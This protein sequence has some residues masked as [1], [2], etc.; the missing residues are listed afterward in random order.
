MRSIIFAVCLIVASA[1][2]FAQTDLTVSLPPGETS[3]TDIGMYRVAYQ[4]YDGQI[5][6]MPDSWVGHFEPVSG[7][8]YMPGGNVSGRPT[9]LLHSPWHGNPGKMWV[10]YRLKLPQIKPLRLGFGIAMGPGMMEPNKSDGVTFSAFVND[11]ELMRE[12]CTSETWKDFT[13]DLDEYAGQ[14]ISVRLQVEPGPNNSPSFDYSYFG[15]PRITAG[16]GAEARAQLVKQLVNTKA[17]LATATADMRALSND[18][19]HGVTPSNLLPGK[20]ALTAKGGG[21]DFTYTGK[22]CTVVYHYE[23]RTGTLADF[24]VSLDGGRAL[25]PAD[26]GGVFGEKRIEDRTERVMLTGGKALAVT[27]EGEKLKVRWEYPADGGPVAVDWTFGI[28]GK[29]LTVEAQCAEPVLVGLSLG[30]VSQ[31]PMRRMLAVPYLP[32]NGMPLCYLPAEN[33]YVSRYLNWMVSHASTCPQG[34]ASYSKKTDGTRNALVESGYV[35]VSPNVN[36]VLPNIPWEASPYVKLL[37]PLVMLD[38]WGHHKGSFAGSA[39]NLR[40]LKDNG[41]DHLAIINHVWQRFGYDVKLPDHVPANPGLGGDEGMIEFGKAAN[42][43]KYVWSCHENYIDLYPDAPSWDPTAAVLKADGTQNFAW[44]NPGTKVQS[45][46]LKCNRALGFAK[47]NAPYVHKTYGT[48]AGYLDVHTCVPP[49]HQLDYDAT[50]PMAGMALGK[51]KYDGEL[52]QY[53]RDTHEGPLFGEGNNQFYWA[54]KCDGVEAQV[55]GGE[56]HTPFLDLDLLKMHP[57]MVNHGMGYYERWFNTMRESRWGR[58]CGTIEQAD[59]YR[60]QT[61]AYGHAGFIGGAQVDNVQ[62]VAKEH[63]LMHPVMALY[64]AAKPTRVAYEIDGKL[65]GASVALAVGDTSR[66]VIDYDSGLKLFVNWNAQPWKVGDKVLPQWGY[67]ATGPGTESYTALKDGKY[68][69]YSECPD[70]LFAD[71]RTSFNM[72]YAKAQKDIEPKLGAFEYL[73]DNKIRL[74][75]NWVVNDTL[76][77]DQQCFVHFTN[78]SN[79]ETDSIIFQQDHALPK[80]TS[81]WKKGET[82]VDGPYEITLPDDKLTHYDIAI[83]L[84]KGPRISM[85]GLE[86]GSTRIVLGR[87]LVTRQDGKVTDVKLADMADVAKTYEPEGPPLDFAVRLN[88]AGTMIDFGKIAT[89]GSVKVE[90]AAKSLTLLPYPRDKQFTV[91]LD[92]KAL[93]PQAKI[94][95]GAVKVRVL[96]AGTKADMGATPVVWAKDR[97]VVKVGQAGAGRYVISW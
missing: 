77:G 89:D 96:A 28:R 97:L 19:S 20:N 53:M 75:Y 42:E 61:L 51:V 12:H 49:W 46:G 71:A 33:A 34:E 39:E 29:A 68:F 66:Q 47:Q 62:W 84:F 17:Y 45:F 35:A 10:D 72:P 67:L 7:I 57:Q 26:G 56:D 40:D 5:V 82:L 21:Y 13:F 90:R 73:G 94:V 74:T 81:E 43:S 64:G 3:L 86:D 91:S 95:P 50:Q 92:L 78:K 16:A 83:G 36:E 31:A 85:K 55:N 22:D 4:P 70:Y 25:L 30:R 24:T 38:V 18:S 41:V 52:F 69:D 44:Y 48:N 9:L 54:G 14:T 80:P 27:P 65:V 37:G 60:A 32:A 79:D 59:K 63:N 58:N 76:E 87:L 11:K 2:G 1:G 88:D 23:P 93:C 15:K 8:S 6:W